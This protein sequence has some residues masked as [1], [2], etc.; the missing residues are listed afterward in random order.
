[1]VLY[2]CGLALKQTQLPQSVRI[3]PEGRQDFL[4][5]LFRQCMRGSFSCPPSA[6]HPCVPCRY[7]LSLPRA[8]W[9][10]PRNT[11][12]GA[13]RPNPFVLKASMPAMF[14]VVWKPTNTE[15]CA[16]LSVCSYSTS[17]SIGQCFPQYRV[18]PV[19][20]CISLLCAS[21]DPT[22]CSRGP[23]DLRDRRKAA[24][25]PQEEHTTGQA[26]LFTTCFS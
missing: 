8:R 4:C 20:L 12:G 5:V 11:P 6:A 26:I 25:H 3:L 15:P 13:Y 14:R 9:W 10:D 23:C 2:G 16:A 24:D 18:I 22:P 7:C 19:L 17:S 1:M 21:L